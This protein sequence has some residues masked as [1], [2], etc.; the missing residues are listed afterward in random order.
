MSGSRRRWNCTP[1]SPAVRPTAPV[2][3]APAVTPTRAATPTS[4]VRVE[5]SD[6]SADPQ[7]TDLEAGAG[8][9]VLRAIEELEWVRDEREAED[10]FTA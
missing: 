9:A 1:S 10:G 2:R 7:S 6:G 8:V 4:S 5:G 3:Y